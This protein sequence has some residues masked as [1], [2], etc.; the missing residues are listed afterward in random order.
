MLDRKLLRD[1]WQLRGQVISIALVVASGIAAFVASLSTYDSLRWLQQSYYDSARFARVFVQLRRA[2]ASLQARLL[3]IPGVAEAETSIS[4][5]VMLDLP[6][7]VEPVVG[8]MVALPER[9]VP[10]L[11][12]LALRAGNWVETRDSNQVLVSEAFANARKLKPGDQLDAV[13]NGKRERLHIVGI[14]LSPEYIFTHGPGGGAEGTFGVLWIGRQRL[15]SAFNME[16]AFNRI[17]LRLSRGASE[18]VVI[19]ALDRLLEPYGSTGAHG[20]DEQI[21]HQ[22]LTQEINEQK[23]FGTVLPSVFLGVAVFLL[24]VVLSRQI[25]V[26]RNQIAALK[27][28]GRPNWQIGSH[29]LKFVL[30]T[31]AIGIVIGVAAGAYLGR[32][33]TELYAQFF[34]FPQFTYRMQLWI[35]LVASA[36][37]LVAAAAG[38]LHALLRVVRL[39]AAEAMRP[40]SPPSFRATLMERLGF[41]R[42]YS[43][44]ARMVV[45]DIERRP[46][47]AVLTVFGI[48][49]AIAIL[50]SGTWWGDAIDYMLEVELR[51]RER[52]DVSLVMAEATSSSGFYDLSHLPGVLRAEADRFAAVRLR[53]GQYSYR[54]SITGLSADSQMRQLL[55]RKLRSVPLPDEGL[56]LNARLAR[57]LGL[58][59]GDPVLVEMLQGAR[60]KRSVPVTGLVEEMM[61]MQAYMERGALNRLLGEGDAISGVRIALDGGARLAFF[62]AM[63]N[64]PRAAAVVELD[65]IIRNFRE[66]SA[67]NILV[68]TSILTVLAGTIAVGVVYNQSRIALAERAWELA[69]LRVL[70]FTRSEVSGLLLAEFALELLL[71]LPLGWLSGYWLSF[72]IVKLIEHET[73]EI[74]LVITAHTYAYAS[75][76]VILA[77]VA[78]ALLVRRRIDR[79][80]LVGVL[81]ARE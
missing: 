44:R 58:R 25:G 18:A 39:P 72:G 1:L 62:Q 19:H 41:E 43:P 20:R 59:L 42:F 30:I 10:R 79:L 48:A 5:D 47:R 73:F 21:S 46:A 11:N 24:N 81:K 8:R 56:V 64:T 31:V 60:T 15:A 22:A 27:A 12:R 78:S 45:R 63:K 52:Q 29:Y 23:V 76:V 36:L 50:I 71:A 26:Q 3:E 54:T 68:F 32:L 16:G 28:L 40:P 51:L 66:T 67:R 33:L 13:L 75:L 14:A 80:D 74:P 49:C 38:A 37:S 57:R 69:S 2:P 34:R 35:P 53:N 70:G 61:Q 7:A 6:G 4:F 9:G 55:D 77:G 17:A 65:P